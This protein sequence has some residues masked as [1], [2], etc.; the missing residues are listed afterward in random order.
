MYK[1]WDIVQPSDR[2]LL[3]LQGIV[4]ALVDWQSALL[5]RPL[6]NK[7]TRQIHNYANGLSRSSRH[8]PMSKTKTMPATVAAVF[9]EDGVLVLQDSPLFGREAIQ[10]FY[11]DLYQKVHF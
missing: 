10:K 11:A 3:L 9:T 7:K 8:V 5:C 2:F 4:V 1:N 6:P